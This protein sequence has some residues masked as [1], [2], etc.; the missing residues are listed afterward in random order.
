MKEINK[1][2]SNKEE[3]GNTKIASVV[4][5]WNAGPRS[6]ISGITNQ[7]AT[8]YL[9]TLL[10]I[11]FHTPDL[12]MAQNTDFY[13]LPQILQEILILFSNLLKGD[14]API[15]AKSLTES[16]GWT[17]D[18]MQIH[19]DIQEL[20]RLLFEELEDNLKDTVE[21]DL[22]NDL[23][24]G[25]LKTTIQC[26]SCGKISER[27]DE[28]QD[29]N[30][31]VSDCNSIE[32][33]LGN[34][35]Q[36]ETLAGD[37]QYFCEK[38]KFTGLP[39]ILT[40]SLSRFYFNP[41][42][43]EAGKLDKM[44]SFPLHLDMTAY[45]ETEQ[46]EPVNYDLFSIVIHV[47]TSACDGHYHAYIKEPYGYV[48][49]DTKDQTT[50]KDSFAEQAQTNT[51]YV[52]AN[53]NEQWK[54]SS[55]PTTPQMRTRSHQYQER[56][57]SYDLT[58]HPIGHLSRNLRGS[59][60]SIEAL[61]NDQSGLN[62]QL[63]KRKSS[64]YRRFINGIRTNLKTDRRSTSALNKHSGMKADQNHIEEV[65]SAGSKS[66][67]RKISRDCISL[68]D[69]EINEVKER[70]TN[71]RRGDRLRSNESKMP[72]SLSFDQV[73]TR[74]PRLFRQTSTL[75]NSS[76][77]DSDA[78]SSNTLNEND[79]PTNHTP[80]LKSEDSFSIQEDLNNSMDSENPDNVK[81]LNGEIHKYDLIFFLSL[82]GKLTNVF[83]NSAKR[84][85][86]TDDRTDLP[87]ISNKLDP[88]DKTDRDAGE[89]ESVEDSEDIMTK[90]KHHNPCLRFLIDNWFTLATIAG[91]GLGFGVAF[92]I[93]ATQPG[94]VALT[95]IS[96]PADIYLRLLQ[97]MILPLI[98]ANIL[99]AIASMNL[100]KEG[101]IG[102][103]G[104]IYIILIDLISACLGAGFA[105]IIRPG[106]LFCSIV[107]GA[108]AR[109]SGKIAKVFIDFFRALSIIVTKIMTPLLL[110]TP[111][112][113]VFMV[114]SSIA[115]R[116]NIESEFVQLGLFVATV[117]VAL[118]I[119]FL[120]IVIVFFLASR[121]NPLRLLKYSTQAFF[122]AFATTSP[123][124]A[125]PEV[126]DGLDKYGV[127][128]QVSRLV[129]PL[130]ATL[131]GDGPAAFIAAAA[132]FVAQNQRIDLNVGQIFTIIVL[133][134]IA[135]LGVPNVPS[136]S[137]V[138]VVT[139]LSAIGVPTE[140]AAFLFA[141]EWLL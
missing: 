140:G 139:V 16:F 10:Q 84:N 7:G 48:P 50:E 8:C 65:L 99:V 44:C 120:I 45:L 9:N 37:N 64:A 32:V 67:S 94:A 62:D 43:M 138:L 110:L 36:V 108:A 18:E 96:M 83:R 129:G 134:F 102:L 34:H 30:L 117:L 136:A 130:T 55:V 105:L 35:T 14:G 82:M 58:S 33:A 66:T 87:V 78:I 115:S 114:A 131:K 39:P 72:Q 86:T 101:K 79:Q 31:S 126:Y 73:E 42:S 81:N 28:F 25:C 51:N 49:T 71:N 61:N 119:H 118:A 13:E 92:A 97:L 41:K 2:F 5:S 123:A 11:L 6:K 59:A 52:S 63:S 40:L 17:S 132:I 69:S 70:V 98:S 12:T 103:I 111:V 54:P 95:W 4:R 19:Q 23:Y 90:H 128:Q 133:T 68:I 60:E 3:F 38:S 47:G 109:A 15:S 46:A 76:I 75:T 127:R 93:R 27:N 141:M 121:K 74:C 91:V 24:K 124:L 137:I 106:V 113:V 85:C 88:L 20:N 112:A 21:K 100:K 77:S 57:N 122:L 1:D 89:E 104:I 29:V 80:I 116:E 135:S 53:N 26:L 125:L 107:F 22:I 56:E